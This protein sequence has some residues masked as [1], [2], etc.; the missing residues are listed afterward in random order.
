MLHIGACTYDD[1]Y[2]RISQNNERFVSLLYSTTSPNCR[3]KWRLLF[4]PAISCY[5]RH[6]DFLLNFLA[7]FTIAFFLLSHCF[8]FFCF[9]HSICTVSFSVYIYLILLK[10]LYWFLVYLISLNIW[11]WWH[12][13]SFLRWVKSLH[14][15]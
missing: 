8:Y 7:S 5:S 3:L 12:V 14:F 2:S 13:S 9:F 10:N 15:Y 11:D 6:F 1:V 4:I